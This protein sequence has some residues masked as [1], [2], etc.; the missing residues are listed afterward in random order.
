MRKPYLPVGGFFVADLAALFSF[1]GLF[2]TI[3]V[4]AQTA[5]PPPPYAYYA[6]G[7]I[8]AQTARFINDVLPAAQFLDEASR[9]ALTHSHDQRIRRM[10]RRIAGQQTMAT[11]TM[12]A[13]LTTGNTRAAG[14]MTGRSVAVQTGNPTDNPLAP[15]GGL[16]NVVTGGAL[17]TQP[18]GMRPGTFALSTH[19]S[20]ELERLAKLRGP[21]FDRLYV[22]TQIDA[23]RQLAVIYR[24]YRQNGDNPG[25]REFAGSALPLLTRTIARLSAL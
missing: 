10:A 24:D 12:T 9:M 4:L 8:S 7:M 13:F 2:A 14:L 6:Q 16:S 23:M 17:G 1:I 21:D 18:M 3:P 5:A 15:V 11:N 19:Q 22:S 20:E 25:L